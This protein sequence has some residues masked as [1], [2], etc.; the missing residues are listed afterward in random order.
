[1][2]RADRRA[3]LGQDHCIS[4]PGGRF[5]PVGVG[6]SSS[7]ST[8]PSTCMPIHR[9][10]RKDKPTCHL[11]RHSAAA[12]SSAASFILS[13]RGVKT[14]SLSIC[15]RP[16]GIA[17]PSV[18]ARL[19]TSDDRGFLKGIPELWTVVLDRMA[20][21]ESILDV[22]DRATARAIGLVR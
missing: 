7:L 3:W 10:G 21:D 2:R 12:R 6:Q 22:R 13:P 17:A 14:I 19:R 16:T 9:S 18:M 15:Y 8:I 1:M 4:S 11:R 20:R 5:T